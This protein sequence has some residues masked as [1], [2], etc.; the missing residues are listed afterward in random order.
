MAISLC[1]TPFTSQT[2]THKKVP[3]FKSIN[4]PVISI[5]PTISRRSNLPTINCVNNNGSSDQQLPVN[6]SG[7][8]PRWENLLST[9][10][11]LYPVYVTVGGIIAC[12]QPSSFSWFVDKGPASYS[13]SLGFI[14]LAMGLTLELKDLINL[15]MERPLSVSYFKVLFLFFSFKDFFSVSYLIYPD[16]IVFLCI[17]VNFIVDI[18]FNCPPF[19]SLLLAHLLIM[20]EHLK[21]Y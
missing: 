13:L 4:N 14:M 9:A 7:T 2:Q 10:A 1:L 15:F 3:I 11:S 16:C 6:L 19:A 8:K 21:I 12:L 18:C 5:K 20:Y 17:W